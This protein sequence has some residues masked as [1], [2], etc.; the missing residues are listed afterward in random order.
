MDPSLHLP[1][2][3]LAP[4]DLFLL[5]LFSA[6][7]FSLVQI[8]GVMRACI[9]ISHQ[10]DN[11][12]TNHTGLYRWLLENV[13]ISVENMDKKVDKHCEVFK[14]K[15]T[16]FTSPTRKRKSLKWIN[17]GYP[18]LESHKEKNQQEAQDIKLSIMCS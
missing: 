7:P 2:F 14:T 9:Y 16:S 1:L 10:P 18:G 5:H 4:L 12:K 17:T 13:Y 8:P 11:S 3:L 15:S 6:S